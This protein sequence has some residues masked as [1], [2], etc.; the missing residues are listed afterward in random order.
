MLRLRKY[1]LKKEVGTLDRMT[2][3]SMIAVMA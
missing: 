3:G 1:E 2:L